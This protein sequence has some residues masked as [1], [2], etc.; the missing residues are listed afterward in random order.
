MVGDAEKAGAGPTHLGQ[1][2]GAGQGDPSPQEGG[3]AVARG[4]GAVA[5]RRGCPAGPADDAAAAAKLNETLRGFGR[6][7]I[8]AMKATLEHE[9]Q[10]LANVMDGD[11]GDEDEDAAP[12]PKPKRAKGA[13]K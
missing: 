13:K 11:D 6:E 3:P 4:G 10:A 9:E 12:P 2:G 8:A 5:A 1:A 7:A